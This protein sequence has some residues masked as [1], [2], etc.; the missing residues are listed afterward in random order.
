MKQSFRIIFTSYE[1]TSVRKAMEKIIGVIKPTGSE[2]SG[3]LPIKVKR[4][5]FTVLRSPH[6][7]KKSREQF[8][9]KQ[10]KYVL[11]IYARDTKAVEALA[12]LELP[13]NIDIQIKI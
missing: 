11:D 10:Y 6:V 4:K 7:N 5:L 1:Y 2:I 13:S 12:G 3:P 9:R 8:M